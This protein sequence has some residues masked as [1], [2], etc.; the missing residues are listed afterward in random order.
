MN[1][2]IAPREGVK[3]GSGPVSTDWL[4]FR[5]VRLNVGEHVLTDAPSGRELGIVL[6]SGEVEVSRGGA[7]FALGPRRGPLEDLPHAAYFP[8]GDRLCVRTRVPS[9]IALAHAE[10][11]AGFEPRRVSPEDLAVEER[12]EGI[13]GRTVRHIL[14]GPG[15]AARLLLV[16]VITPGGHWSSFPPHRHDEMRP[17][18]R[19]LLEEAYLFAVAPEG[20]RALMG[21]WNDRGETVAFAPGH[22]DLVMVRSGY[23]TVS[24]AP[25]SQLYYLNAMAGPER[26]WTPVFQPG[27]EH[28]VTGW[29]RAPIAH[30][31]PEGGPP[32]P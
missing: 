5:S 9:W 20:H 16:E 29:G 31:L 6:L 27:Y 8:E 21:V 12:G 4:G 13:T 25:G 19:Y 23:H 30:A 17:P 22:G 2:W 11:G 24:A 1:A 32:E 10:G 14:E 15:E 18:S 26:V 28:L 7:R 3:P